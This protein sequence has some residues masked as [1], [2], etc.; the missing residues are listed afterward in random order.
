MPRAAPW[1]AWSAWSA[2]WAP[3]GSMLLL[4]LLSYI[5]RQTLAVLSPS[6]LRE[7]GLNAESYGWVISAFSV[8]YLV[9]NPIWGRALDRFGVRAGLAVAAAFWA[10]ASVS[11][12]FA[13]TA[14]GFA[15]ARAALG[16]GEG[17]TFPGGLRTAMQTLRADQRAR[18]VALAYSGG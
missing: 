5:D 9:G 14:G 13:S 17:A 18:G 10:C 15:I 3:T 7:T 6:I 1:S 11:H 8:A 16:F 12:A 4:S 2:W